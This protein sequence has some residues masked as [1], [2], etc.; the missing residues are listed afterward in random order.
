MKTILQSFPVIQSRLLTASGLV[1][2]CFSTRLG[3]KSTG[4]YAAMNLGFG[5]GEEREIVAENMSALCQALGVAEEKVVFGKQVH[6]VQVY[7]L[8]GQSPMTGRFQ[9]SLTGYDAL[10]TNEPSWTLVT[11]HADCVPVFLL[12]PC[13]RAI[14]MIHAGWRGTAGR[15]V[16]HTLADME[17]AYD[18]RPQDV[19]AYIGPSIGPCCFQVGEEVRDAF[20][21]KIPQSEQAIKRDATP[22]KWKIDLWAVNQALLQEAGV[23]ETQ[24]EIE[25]LCTMCHGELFYSHRAMGESRGSMAAFLSLKELEP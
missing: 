17:T 3:G 2:H 6:D 10:M 4:P 18:T 8:A 22:Q 7:Q 9:S 1:R 21:E 14:A 20:L 16:Q 5:R 15:I 24:I 11:Y 13:H 25:G 19:L 23:P 12:D